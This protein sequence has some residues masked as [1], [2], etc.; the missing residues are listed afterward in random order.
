MYES[1]DLVRDTNVMTI[2]NG[3]ECIKLG[4]IP[5]IVDCDGDGEHAFKTMENSL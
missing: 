5:P 2:I 1:I 3:A 4:S